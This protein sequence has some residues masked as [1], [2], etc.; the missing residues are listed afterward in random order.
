MVEHR[1][2]GGVAERDV[3]QLDGLTPSPS[4][5]GEGGGV[6]VFTPLSIRRGVGGEAFFFLAEECRHAVGAGAPF[7]DLGDGGGQL[8]GGRY[9]QHEEHHVADEE[10]GRQ[11]VVA[12]HD[13]QRAEEQDAHHD[14][15]AQEVADGR[16]GVDA[17][18]HRR[19]PPRVVAVVLLEAVVAELDGRIGL[20]D[21]QASDGL[22]GERHQVR[23][24]LLHGLRLALQA[25][26]EARDDEGHQRQ[27]AEHEERKLQVEVEQHSQVE[28][29]AD[30]RRQQHLHRA[31]DVLVILHHVAP[32]ARQHVAFA[33][34]VVVAH[35]KVHGF[36][37]QVVTY[38]AHHPRAYDA[39]LHGREVAEDVLQ[40][41]EHEDDGREEQ[42][43][44]EAPEAYQPGVESVEPVG[45]KV[46]A[47]H[48]G[49]HAR[50]LVAEEYLQEV[51][52]REG[53]GHGE[54]HAQ[55]HQQR[56]Q[57]SAS[58]VGL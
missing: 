28:H 41:V 22:V 40:A 21:F 55:H 39:Y 30:D 43:R 42:Q 11:A 51:G 31:E 12:P 1:H 38:I 14:E 36:A 27:H 18:E 16:G 9:H 56:I 20:D 44:V 46:A 23:V 37:E 48:R 17:A 32:E 45:Y 58:T 33:L 10:V 52:H 50:G 57:C 6:Q 24:H 34:P 35:G 13:E 8:L 49:T 2:A 7:L 47:G 26:R 4:P 53:R 54:H 29:H 3:A 5:N 19:A 15:V 25:A